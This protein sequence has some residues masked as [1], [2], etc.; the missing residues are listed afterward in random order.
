M[1]DANNIKKGTLLIIICALSWGG[2]GILSQ[3]LINYKNVTVGWLVSTRMLIAGF[4]L[5]IICIFKYGSKIFSIWKDK[6]I[7]RELLFFSLIA[8][9][10]VQFTYFA[11]IKESNAATATVIQYI[12]PILVLIYM[13]VKNKERPKT[14]EVLVIIMAF[15]GIGLIATHGHINKL[16]IT[17]LALIY[18]VISACAMAFY[19]IYPVNSIYKKIGVLL[20]MAW[21][22]L[23]GGITLVVCSKAYNDIVRINLN[24]KYCL[25]IG[26][27]VL[28]GSLIPAIFYGVGVSYI[29]SKKA[30]ILSTI[31]PVV[32]ALLVVIFYSNTFNILDL[33][34]FILIISAVQITAM[35]G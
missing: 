16:A 14:Y 28:L 24:F 34:G 35:K 2:N 23:L 8:I 22:Y 15:I 6:R 1:N 20:T 30:S 29:G 21:A 32:C 17:T 13:S 33:L 26:L 10:I 18:G 25:L 9:V 5:L 11:A 7:R 3:V 31:E 4:I 27:S 19:T 12:F